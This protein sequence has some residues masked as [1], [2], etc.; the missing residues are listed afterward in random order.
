MT[1]V[2]RTAT[3]PDV[4]ACAEMYERGFGRGIAALFGRMP[5]RAFLED[6]LAAVLAVEPDALTVAC[7]GTEV[8]GY[9][10]APRSLRRIVGRAFMTRAAWRMIGGLLSGRYGVGH[11]LVLLRVA[12]ESWRFARHAGDFRTAGDAQ[13][14]SIAVREDARGQGVAGLLMGAALAYL[15]SCGEREVRLEVQPDNVAAR[16]VYAR[17]GFVERGEIPSPLGRAIVMTRPLPG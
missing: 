13:I 5:R 15:A 1:V 9:V 4:P 2:C 3:P 11:P 10:M 8:L 16:H 6:H 7:R 17:L 12:R 14:V